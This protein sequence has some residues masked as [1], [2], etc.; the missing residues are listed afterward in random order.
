MLA[1]PDTLSDEDMLLHLKQWNRGGSG[2]VQTGVEELVVARTASL[3]N[4]RQAV[5]RKVQL[6][7]ECVRISK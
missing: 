6:P 1:C 3:E 4:V 5:A 7:A 2:L